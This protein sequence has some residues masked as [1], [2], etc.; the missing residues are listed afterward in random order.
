MT[1]STIKEVVEKAIEIERHGQEFYER[2]KNAVT[3]PGGKA[4]LEYLRRAEVEHESSL[5]SLLSKLPDTA[6]IH[7]LDVDV[8]SLFPPLIHGEIDDVQSMEVAVDIEIATRDL[9][10]RWASL[11]QGEAEDL[12]TA[13]AEMEDGH[14]K[15]LEENLKYIEDEGVWYG[16]VPILQG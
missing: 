4:V 16:Y 2:F 15:L 11:S 6:V 3:D 7:D 1:I 12:F 8:E 10:R 14:R 5:R 9:Y 13:L